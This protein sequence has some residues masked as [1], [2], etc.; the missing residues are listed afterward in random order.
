MVVVD[1]VLGEHGH[2]YKGITKEMGDGDEETDSPGGCHHAQPDGA[3]LPA[4]HAV[5]G[6]HHG[7]GTET[8]TENAFRP[9]SG[10]RHCHERA[11]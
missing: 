10:H 11:G 8:G 3:V 1:P 4:G 7:R 2:L 5:S 9:G 6:A